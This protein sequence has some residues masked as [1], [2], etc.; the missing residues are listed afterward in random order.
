MKKLFFMLGCLLVLSSYPVMAVADD[1]A[2]VVVRIFES[3]AI[4]EFTVVRGTGQP[5]YYKFESGISTKD[6][7]AAGT[8]YQEVLSKLYAQGYVLQQSLEGMQSESWKLHT[9]I[10]IKAPKP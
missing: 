4:L 1:P 5:E 8:G 2:V 9:L 3:R 10:F 6:M 7:A